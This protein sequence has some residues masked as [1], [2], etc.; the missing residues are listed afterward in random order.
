[1]KNLSGRSHNILLDSTRKCNL[2]VLVKRQAAVASW[3]SHTDQS[4]RS[5]DE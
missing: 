1:M 3:L 4:K 5:T 2:T